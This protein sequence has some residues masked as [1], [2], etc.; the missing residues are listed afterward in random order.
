MATNSNNIVWA[1]LVTRI[2]AADDL[3]L[4]ALV[5]L[6]EASNTDVKDRTGQEITGR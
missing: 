1:A 6:I 5:D 3:P 4:N 2:P